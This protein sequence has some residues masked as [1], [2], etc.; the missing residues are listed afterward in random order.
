M[1]RN[2]ALG[3]GIKPVPATGLPLPGTNHHSE[4]GKEEGRPGDR[5]REPGG[6]ATRG[7]GVHRL[8]RPAA[9]SGEVRRLGVECAK[10]DRNSQ[11]SVEGLAW[12]AWRLSGGL[13]V[14]KDR[15]VAA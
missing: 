14:G 3:S 4:S 12:G 13:A 15:G 11:R 1:R 6:A 8:P 9:A 5:T 7:R 10:S 2:L